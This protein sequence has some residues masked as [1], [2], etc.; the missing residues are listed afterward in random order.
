[1]IEEWRSIK[2]FPKYKVSNLG[3]VKSANIILKSRIHYSCN[4]GY[5]RAAL[6]KEGQV[7]YFL[8]HRLV[9]ETFIGLPSEIDNIGHHKDGNRSNNNLS[10]LEWSNHSKNRI[11]SIKG[12]GEYRS[13]LK[14]R[15]VIEIRRLYKET[16]ITQKELS[17]IYGIAK[18]TVSSIIRRITWT[19]I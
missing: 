10:N 19:H 5:A 4:A 13:N 6:T 15:D 17:S 11:D 7:H 14:E 8:V 12:R 9:L 16:K 18:T 3:R 1:M 2:D